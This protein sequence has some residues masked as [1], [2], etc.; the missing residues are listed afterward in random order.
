MLDLN[1]SIKR[2]RIVS[3]FL[4]IF[5]VVALI[6]MLLIHNIITSFNYSSDSFY[7]LKKKSPIICSKENNF[8]SNYNIIKKTPILKNCLLKAH[9]RYISIN[10][11]KIN[12]KTYLEKYFLNNKIKNEYKSQKIEL[13]IYDTN[14]INQQCI[15]NHKTYKYYNLF[16]YGFEFIYNIKTNKNYSAGTKSAVYPFLYGETSISNIAKRYPTVFIFKPFLFL[17]SILM[18]LY[19]L[20]YNKIYNHIFKSKNKVNS[21]LTF[22]TLSAIFLFLHVFFLGKSI[23]NEFF[24]IFRKIFII[25]FILFEI[26][27]Q[28]FLV[29]KL[30]KIKS[31]LINLISNKIL[32]IKILLVTFV[33]S[34]SVIIIFTLSIFDLSKNVDYFLEW[35][36]FLILL[37]FYLLSFLMW[38]KKF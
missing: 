31:L 7:E 4:F 14:E 35:N 20:N 36:Y 18:L 34:A 8:C 28:Y 26:I 13:I 32:F 29:T 27:A 9:S 38:K 10:N 2:L 25:L 1:Q 19:W 12:L 3:L 21:F 11:K 23:N 30:Y 17:S 24:D 33:L 37:F 6:G 15:K 22:G 16:P 5:P